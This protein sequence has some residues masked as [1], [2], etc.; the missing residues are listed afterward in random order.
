MK[1][2]IG[3]LLGFGLALIVAMPSPATA[4]SPTHEVIKA[5]GTCYALGTDTLGSAHHYP[6]QA[7][8]GTGDLGLDPKFTEAL[9]IYRSCFAS[10]F[11]FNII[12]GNGEGPTIPWAALVS[13]PGGD[14]ALEWANFVNRAFRGPAASWNCPNDANCTVNQYESTQHQLGTQLATANGNTGTLQSYL[15]ATHTYHQDANG[16]SLDAQ[17]RKGMSV[18]YGTY[19][20]KVVLER[21]KW[22]IQE[23]NLILRRGV[24]LP[25]VSGVPVP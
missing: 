3:M 18:A 6:P 13:N 2:T 14:R 12:L 9:A 4:Q 23:R 19:V 1:S 21:G 22:K 17:G 5:L 20:N 16:N 7:N 15:T 8:T 24:A 11:E 10:D 25:H